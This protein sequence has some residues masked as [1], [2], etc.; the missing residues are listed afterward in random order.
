L[1]AIIAWTL[2]YRNFVILGVLVMAVFGV[3]SY[4][5]LPI[6]AFPDVTNVQVEVLSTA[7]GLSALEIERFVTYPIE[8]AMRGLPDVVQMRSITKFSLSVVTSSPRQGRHL[9]CPA[10]GFPTARGSKGNVQ[11]RCR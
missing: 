5:N 1:E 10:A 9:F 2:R 4:T 7:P 11:I 6:D 3:Y 8:N